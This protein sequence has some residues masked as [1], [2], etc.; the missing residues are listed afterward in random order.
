[1]K[2]LV[3]G[4]TGFIGGNVAR[5]LVREGYSVRALVRK[6]SS[7]KALEGL[8]LDIALGDLLDRSSLEKALEG[9]Q[10]LFHVAA[11][12]TFWSR[13][14][15]IIYRT[16]VQGTENILAAARTQRVRKIIYT[17]S[18]SVVGIDE[19]CLVGDETMQNSLRR[20]PSDYKKS[21]FMAEQLVFAQCRQGLPAVVVN[22]TTPIGV[23]DVKPTPTGGIVVSYLEGRMFACVNTGLNIIDV[24]DVA[25]GHILALEKGRLGERYLLGNRNVTL[26]EIFAL[27]EKITGIKAPRFNIPIGLALCAGYID[28]VVEAKI[29]RRRPGIPLAA[30][31]AARHF[32]HFDCSK[33]VM[34]LGLPQT[35]IETAFTK[36]VRWFRENG[37]IHRPTQTPEVRNESP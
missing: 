6:N 27:L 16:N 1:M 35:P 11:V 5:Q 9:C 22:P 4:A 19:G 21:K 12:Y 29:L 37:Y 23:Y 3:T 34:E 36:A 28:D 18:E 31:K 15:Q 10:A 17:S 33:A 24:E 8:D 7:L 14:P 25:R 20:I 2:V 13:D 32:R 30:V 26:R